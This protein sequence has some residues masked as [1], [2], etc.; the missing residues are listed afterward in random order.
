MEDLGR[1]AAEVDVDAVHVHDVTLLEAEPGNRD[2]EVVD[3]RRAVAGAVDEHESARAGAGERALGDPGD[4]RRPDG[5]VHGV[6]ARGEHVGACL[7][8]QRVTGCDC[9]SHG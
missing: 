7:C 2:E 9:P 3:P 5:S 4:E 1:A 8:G 6:S